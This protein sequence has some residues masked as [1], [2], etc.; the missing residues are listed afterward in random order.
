MLA[1]NQQVLPRLRTPRT[2]IWCRF[3]CYHYIYNNQWLHSYIA[4]LADCTCSHT[5]AVDLGD[6]YFGVEVRSGTKVDL[7]ILVMIL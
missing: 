5:S 4:E 1:L 6:G 7:Y 3:T 2:H